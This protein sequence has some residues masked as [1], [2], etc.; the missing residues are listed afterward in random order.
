[1]GRGNG[2]FLNFV[3]QPSTCTATKTAL[4]IDI[5]NEER[6][7]LV[8]RIHLTSSSS[9]TGDGLYSGSSRSSGVDSLSLLLEAAL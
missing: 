4:C 8:I 9:D 5:L 3:D 7:A 1:M 2:T 6:D